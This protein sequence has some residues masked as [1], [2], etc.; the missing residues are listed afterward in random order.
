VLFD[1]DPYL[2]KIEIANLSL[3]IDDTGIDIPEER[4]E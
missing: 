4:R 1:A 2:F 3:R